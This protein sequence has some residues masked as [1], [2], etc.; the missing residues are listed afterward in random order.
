MRLFASVSV[1]TR[2]DLVAQDQEHLL[3]ATADVERGRMVPMSRYGAGQGAPQS[4][5]PGIRHGAWLP[6]PFSRRVF[7]L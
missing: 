7:A 1:K 3:P 4:P 5:G 2:S 6:E